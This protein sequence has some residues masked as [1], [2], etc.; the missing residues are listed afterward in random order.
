MSPLP[1][2]R[3]PPHSPALQRASLE[4]LTGQDRLRAVARQNLDRKIE[5]LTELLD[6]DCSYAAVLDDQREYFVAGH[7]MV[8]TALDLSLTPDRVLLN[9][10]RELRIHSPGAFEAV[11]GEASGPRLSERLGWQSSA[12]VRL[13]SLA[14]DP[15]V[16]VGTAHRSSTRFRIEDCSLFKR[17]A[18]DFQRDLMN[19]HQNATKTRWR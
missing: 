5:S 19:R 7:N 10:H 16:I 1:A 6:S 15:A 14:S 3:T 17:W 13:P 4:T 11:D 18:Q 9:P 8:L 2:H 12:A